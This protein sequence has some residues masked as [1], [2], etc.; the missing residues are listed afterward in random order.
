MKIRTLLLFLFFAALSA[1]AHTISYTLTKP[2]PVSLAIYNPAGVLVRTVYSA[3][4]QAAGR[5]TYEWDGLDDEG[6]P[7]PDARACTWK[8][9]QRPAPLRAD[10]LLTLLVTLPQGGEWWETGV[11]NHSGV[12]AVAADATGIYVGAGISENVA[13]ALKMNPEGT[14]R[15]WS[16]WQPDPFKGRWA[17]GLSKGN[18]YHL[19]QDGYVGYHPV[20]APNRLYQS[21]GVGK[22]QTGRR[23]DAQWPGTKRAGGYAWLPVKAQ[24]MDMAAHDGV[25]VI[26]Y[27]DQDA[28]QFRQPDDGAVLT[29]VAVDAPLGVAIDNNG[30]ALVISGNAVLRVT[31]GGK[32][33]P[34]LS[35]LDS[36]WRLDVDRRNGDVYVAETAPSHRVKRFSAAGKLLWETGREGG[37]AYGNY[38]PGHFK[39][40]T[41]IAATGNG[42][43]VAEDAAPRRV[44]RFDQA[45][46]FVKEWH[47][48]TQWVPSGAPD[49]DDPT[50]VW[51]RADSYDLLRLK[52]DFA[53]RTY[54]IE[55]IYRVDG[56]AG[57]RIGTRFEGADEGLGG[58]F[59]D[60]TVRKRNGNT[61]LA[62]RERMQV[63]RVDEKTNSLKPVVV[64][65]LGNKNSNLWTDGDG[66]GEPQPGEVRQYAWGE[67]GI[68]GNATVGAAGDLDYYRYNRYANKVYRVPV[69]KF[70]AAGAPVY[71]PLPD[72][73]TAVPKFTGFDTEKIY[74]AKSTGVLARTD[75]RLFVI[76]NTQPPKAG[77][78]AADYAQLHIFDA[79]GNY[80]ARVGRHV[81]RPKG[82]YQFAPRPEPGEV[83]CFKNLVGSVYDVAV[84]ADFDGGFS[85]RLSAITYAWDKNGLF[86]GGLFDQPNTKGVPVHQY[87]HSGDNGSGAILAEK[88]TGEALY[89]A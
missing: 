4:P 38:Q 29:T 75:D 41:D 85:G 86:V 26:S 23:W 40:I 66:D 43:L 45:G 5:Q 82:P 62:R 44:A 33:D 6:Q 28:V 79:K 50:T 42:F 11:G 34:F 15:L 1:S 31:R 8:L 32:T 71:A 87:Y 27:R 52:L 13:N 35:G 49:P 64:A 12:R 76:I 81:N 84:A 88:A 73:E 70:N 55:S 77:W 7:V 61:Y 83:Y 3:K 10:Y 18:L 22:N 60:W 80:V 16:A 25:M 56:L 58:G 9:L 78:N 36:P 53:A 47:T 20:N 48:G 68:F 54:R 39:N 89:Y 72:A 57:K 21:V 24:S 14:K 74:L 17:Y 65:E 46:K 30:D 67:T 37:R 2:G 69:Q 19:Q 63:I 59:G 51:A